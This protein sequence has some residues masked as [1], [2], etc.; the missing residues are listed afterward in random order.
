[1]V[2]QGRFLSHPAL[3][4]P[5]PH[6]GINIP[7]L[8]SLFA[9]L[10]LSISEGLSHTIKFPFRC[11]SQKTARCMRLKI[12]PVSTI[13]ISP[14]PRSIT[15][16]ISAPHKYSLNESW[17]TKIP[18]ISTSLY[19]S[20]SLDTSC[21]ASIHFTWFLLSLQSSALVPSLPRSLLWFLIPLC[22]P[23]ITCMYLSCHFSHCDVV[24]LLLTTRYFCLLKSYWITEEGPWL[25]PIFSHQL[26]EDLPRRGAW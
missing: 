5:L 22:S 13:T 26:E 21:F 7:F 6:A 11:L 1:M 14:V 16:T 12:L 9:V 4:L 2:P 23:T 10:L 8:C 19:F 18:H 25:I 17:N 20:L 15:G 3:S 24:H